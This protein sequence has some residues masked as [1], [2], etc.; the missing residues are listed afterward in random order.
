M[1]KFFAG[2]SIFV[3]F[4]AI[5]SGVHYAQDTA[6]PPEEKLDMAEVERLVKQLDS[7]EYN[8]REAATV[9]LTELG[10]KFPE[11]IEAALRKELNAAEPPSAEV[12]N[13][14]ELVLGRLPE[15]EWQEFSDAPEDILSPN[16]I[17]QCTAWTGERLLI[18]GGFNPM[19]PSLCVDGATY[20]PNT[21]TWQKLPKAPICGRMSATAIW[22]GAKMIAWG[23]MDW[24][25]GHKQIAYADGAAYD[26]RTEAWSKLPEAPLDGRSWHTAV[27]TG[28]KMII[29]GGSSTVKSF[30]DGAMYDVKTGKWEK[31]PQ[32]PIGPR[33]CHS[34]IWTG[35]KMIIWGGSTFYAGGT[36]LGDGAAYDISLGKW[37]ELPRAPIS[38]R[39][40]HTA[41][42]T[43]EE[44]II[45]GG[46]FTSKC[47]DSKVMADG[48]GYDLKKNTW[49]KLP[50]APIQGLF[51]HTAFWT[52]NRMIVYG[53]L[54]SVFGVDSETD[55]ACFVVGQREWKKPPSGPGGIFWPV[56]V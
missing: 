3:S 33:C 13:T 7:D 12:Q 26:T 24:G 11:E 35:Q 2:I 56:A 51:R 8:E 5:I 34:A 40:L 22:T 37:E 4:F 36:G 21:K 25:V 39:S 28:E 32:A 10:K 15:G 44:M 49:A 55:F 17:G 52:G 45:W 29:W 14:I 42:W 43:G 47:S 16:I 27:W 18:W 46:Y 31:L 20:D 9:S 50:D 53:K 6:K 48:A 19:S 30:D 54:N 1:G 38:D 23:G 41:V